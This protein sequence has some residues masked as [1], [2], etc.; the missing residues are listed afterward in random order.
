MRC[1][2]CHYIGFDS[3]DRCRNCG[4]DF[5]LTVEG[6]PRD[7]P[8]VTP[9][10]PEGPL[11]DFALESA[12]PAPAR[13]PDTASDLPLFARAM[14]VVDRPLVA[15]PVAPRPPLAV[16][17][18]SPAPARP[19]G[20]PADEPTL[21][22]GGADKSAQR[23]RFGLLGADEADASD[24]STASLLM[25][26]VAGLIDI[27][28]LA[29]IHAAV[30]YLTLRLCG[31]TS[32]EIRV[33]PLVPLAAFLLML[34][35][36]YTISFTV[37]GGQT[38]GKMAAGIRVVPVAERDSGNARVPLPSAVLRA[39]GCLVSILAAGLGFLPALFSQDRRAL[40]DRL[41]D[42]RVVRA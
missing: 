36:G 31:L 6:P 40:H 29:A 7:L 16:R 13:A 30:I 15:P 12:R 24:S 28:L 32:A 23:G 2:K 20:R 25:R 8:I 33:L 34:A 35:G 39:V 26:I 37:A 10:D 9:D 11:A 3:G 5:S 21:D 42:T 14:A 4:Y 41:A 19:R 18:S 17:K 1:P 38:I 22:L 27:A